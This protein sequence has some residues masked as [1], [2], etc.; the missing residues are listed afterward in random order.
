MPRVNYDRSMLPYRTFARTVCPAT[1]L[2]VAPK[3]GADGG[4]AVAGACASAAYARGTKD[5]LR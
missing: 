2:L 4:L 1:G 5:C 3:L